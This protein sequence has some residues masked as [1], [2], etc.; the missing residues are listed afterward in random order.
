MCSKLLF[1]IENDTEKYLVSAI[2]IVFKNK[3]M[4]LHKTIVF[5]H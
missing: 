3:S 5:M 4:I 1:F 2:S